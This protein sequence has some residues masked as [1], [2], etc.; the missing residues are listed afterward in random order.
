MSATWFV[1]SP[2]SVHWKVKKKQRTSSLASV[3]IPWAHCD[4]S[5][6]KQCLRLLKSKAVA[7]VPVIL[8][9]SLSYILTAGL[10]RSQAQSC[11]IEGLIC[12]L[13]PGNV[14]NHRL[15]DQLALLE[16][17]GHFLWFS[18]WSVGRRELESVRQPN[19]NRTHKPHAHRWRHKLVNLCGNIKSQCLRWFY[20]ITLLMSCLFPLRRYR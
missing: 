2:I 6:W 20:V 15:L 8:K 16:W 12:H 11:W 17:N 4:A 7:Y 19:L 10:S 13:T 5:F 18:E 1:G 3:F 14:A 9:N